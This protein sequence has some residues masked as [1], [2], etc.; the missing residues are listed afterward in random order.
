[1]FLFGAILVFGGIFFVAHILVRL[2]R[3][4]EEL[5]SLREDRDA[6]RTRHLPVPAPEPVVAPPVPAPPLV[7]EAPA[8]VAPPRP[9]PVIAEKPAPEPIPVSHAARLALI[10]EAALRRHGARVDEAPAD[11][12]KAA[13]SAEELVGGIWLQ[14]AGSIL[15]L[16]GVFFLILWGYTTGRFGPGVIVAAGV[17]L[18]GVIG[19]RGDRL[20]RKVPAFGHAL[21]GIGLG[22]AYISL[23]LGHFALNV[24]NPLGT[25]VL[26]ALTSIVGIL[27]AQRYKVQL[28]AVLAVIGAF[29]P[30]IAAVLTA[31]RGFVDSPPLLLLYLGA[32]DAVVFVLA[33][34]S[35]WPLLALL[36]LLLTTGTWISAVN[37][38]YGWPV[39]WGL[40]ALFVGLGLAP[41]RRLARDQAGMAALDAAVVV[42]APYLFA[43]AAWPFL[44]R[45]PRESVGAL[46]LALAAVE[47]AAAYFVRTV[48]G[49]AQLWNVLVT[50]ASIFL[51]AALERMLGR[52]WTPMSW[53]VEGVVLSAI[54]VAFRSR[55]LR[56]IGGMA[57]L[58][59]LVACLPA[60]A[61]IA[62]ASAEPPLSRAWPLVLF[63]ANSVRALVIVIAL[64]VGTRVVEQSEE[65]G[66]V[67][68]AAW[69][70]LAEMTLFLWL[71]VHATRFAANAMPAPLVGAG[72]L[73]AMRQG[74]MLAVFSWTS[75]LQAFAAIARGVRDR[76]PYRR[77]LGY[78][79]AVGASCSFLMAGLQTFLPGSWQPADGAFFHPTALFEAMALLFFLA[80]ATIATRFRD[81]LEGGEQRLPEILTTGLAVLT[82]MWLGIETAHWARLLAER[83]PE[84]RPVLAPVMVAL[85]WTLLAGDHVWMGLRRGQLYRR[86]VGYGIGATAALALL[87][88]LAADAFSEGPPDTAVR[89][90][91]TGI[92]V[93]ILVFGQVA[94]AR[95]G[96]ARDGLQSRERAVPQALSALVSLMTWVFLAVESTH[97]AR[98]L[99]AQPE[100]LLVFALMALAW[101][102]QGAASLAL[103]VARGSGFR[104]WIGYLVLV[105]AA[106]AFLLGLTTGQVTSVSEAELPWRNLAAALFVTVLAL[107]LAGANL[108]SGNRDRLETSERQ[109]PEA[110]AFAFNAMLMLWAAQHLSF[111]SRFLDTVDARRA[112]AV[113]TSA[114]WVVQAAALFL[115]GWRRQSS[116]LRWLGLGLFGITLG[117][118]ALFDLA[119]VDVFWRFLIAIFFGAV[120][121]AISYVYQRS[122]LGGRKDTLPT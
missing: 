106:F 91:A 107:W 55:Y 45:A 16:L 41:V 24:L 58:L 59:G 31:S 88:G 64:Y 35:R 18:G 44:S 43:V 32:I 97:A 8:V 113:L 90:L 96:R 78:A 109:T 93:A 50:A 36:A 49:R 120:L 84:A 116:F 79:V 22:A 74:L 111:V 25:T 46:L 75:A 94:A 28:I 102:L 85:A 115:V 89:N 100:P 114:A 3:V 69:T 92:L 104:R 103:G 13:R 34:R 7:V 112:T 54:G 21:I 77:A 83:E 72:N 26:L 87:I 63:T 19:W 73:S 119:F 6:Q 117:K 10:E 38:P 101:T 15:L 12:E 57:S 39:T 40:A 110:I 80:G 51:T 70:A 30:Q 42:L 105:T 86:I 27:V 9:K 121:L 23:Y 81:R 2:G 61:A 65:G 48:S 5:R 33:A 62:G 66:D 37:E 53:V 20:A 95:F 17:V 4:E 67:L 60:L 108:L 29:V 1:V 56:S 99:D 98:I 11:T 122:R 118:V 71:G 82:W 76:K 47:A 52:T 14:N 68:P